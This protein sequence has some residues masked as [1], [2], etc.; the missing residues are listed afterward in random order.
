MLVTLLGVDPSLNPDHPL[1]T[2]NPHVTYAYTKHLWM[3]NQKEQAFRQLHH[4]VQA[5]LQPQSAVAIISPASTPEEPDRH[6]ELGKLLARCYLRLGQWQESLQGINEQSIP[7]VLQYY[8]AATE[9]DST[10]YKAWHAWAYMNFEAVLFFKH[11]GQNNTSINQTILG[12][13]T[14]SKGL[15]IVNNLGLSYF[16]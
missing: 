5:S 6:V 3:S 14:P 4:F 8:A 9:H 7:A 11:Q 16:H 2:L 15:V 13:T 10:W 1:P 12:D